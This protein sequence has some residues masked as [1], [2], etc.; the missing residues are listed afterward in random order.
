MQ[1]NIKGDFA[2]KE[3][4]D[5]YR[6]IEG[7]RGLDTEESF[8]REGLQAFYNHLIEAEY[9]STE[10]EFDPS[11]L[12]CDYTQY[13]NIEEFHEDY[14]KEDYPDMESIQKNTEVIQVNDNSFIINNFYKRRLKDGKIH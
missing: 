5:I 6:F 7:F 1:L 13:T 9:G 8:T 3:T 4:I 14:D 12:D 10:T 11:D 2:M